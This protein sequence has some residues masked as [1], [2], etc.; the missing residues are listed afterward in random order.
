MKIE[1]RN[2]IIKSHFKRKS[3]LV[4][5]S[6][7]KTPCG[8]P[9]TIDMS[10]KNSELIC[11]FKNC[12]DIL[13]DNEHLVADKALRNVSYFLSLKLI[14]PQIC[15]NAID[16][17][18]YSGYPEEVS[19]ET[20][21]YVKFSNLSKIPV[22]NLFDNLKFLWEYILSVHPKTKNIFLSD[23]FFDI[24][25]NST[26]KKIIE[27]LNS[28][29]FNKVEEDILGSAYEDVI[30]DV[31]VGKTLGQFFTP[32]K[33]KNL[34]VNLIN[35]VIKEDGTTETIFDPAMGTGG[36]LITCAKF[37][38]NQSKERNIK[39][40]WDFISKYGLG[41][42]EAEI[43]T[44]QLAESNMLIST[45]HMFEALEYGDSIRN[46]ITNKY[47]IILANPPFGIKGLNYN[48][49]SN[50]L[51]D[52]Y[53]PIKS[54]SSVPLF[55]QAII[56]MLNI[57]GRCAVVIPDGKDLFAKTNE[58]INLRKL[59]MKCCELKEIIQLP[60]DIFTNTSIKT[61]IFYFIKKCEMNRVLTIQD[62]A[63]TRNYT[64]VEG[65]STSS[66]KFYT[67][68][69]ETENKTLIS[70]I[71]IEDIAKNDYSLNH[72]EYIKDNIEINKET[73]FKTLG[74]ICNFL[75]KSKRQASYG[76]KEGKYPFFKSSMKL[77][78]YVDEPD[79][80]TESII[81]GDGGEPNVN[82]GIN[83]SVSDHC[84]VLQNKDEST[85][86]KYVY[87]YLLNNLHIMS[88]LYTGVA[89]KNI[90]KTNIQK[91]PIPIPSLE[92][93]K[94]ILNYIEDNER[95][96]KQIQRQI[97]ELHK[98]INQIKNLNRES[99]TNNL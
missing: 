50:H 47:D 60:G 32:P 22:E 80:T 59:L 73:Q 51:R 85:L 46:T 6:N 75:P 39:L 20:L 4:K 13:R 97:E 45:G 56:Y 87:Y 99:F 36:F 55:I 78:S 42:R 67:Y 3:D 33:V 81:I 71:N 69:P 11:I 82:Y 7:R 79:Y 54:S 29:D 53:L 16:M 66:V 95:N 38:I 43:D 15:S 61:C 23:K 10:N 30:K 77:D 48:D 62:K 31:M 96:V 86:I 35:P 72:D 63:R 94:E 28:F 70:E 5:H 64:F 93:Q 52:E 49:I 91:I 34:M 76:L 18:N 83:F 84:Y 14:E 9:I 12:F 58:L 44:F 2:L 88:K 90:S 27:K 40:N 19:K 98:Q 24:K 17:N 74:E 21:E 1:H 57:N 8:I 89:I 37:F 26:F 68:N 65:H 25:N 92:K 41:G